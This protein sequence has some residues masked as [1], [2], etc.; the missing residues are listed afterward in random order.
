MHTGTGAHGLLGMW[1]QVFQPLR[2]FILHSGC[3]AQAGMH[4]LKATWPAGLERVNK[5]YPSLCWCKTLPRML[6]M[7]GIAAQTVIHVLEAIRSTGLVESKNLPF[8]ARVTTEDLQ[9]MPSATLL[10]HEMFATRH[11]MHLKLRSDLDEWKDPLHLS[12]PT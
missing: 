2:E 6:S 8:C 10:T 12:Q 11:D 3:S 5:F 4:M 9:H 7:S 1:K